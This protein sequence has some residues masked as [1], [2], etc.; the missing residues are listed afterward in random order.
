MLQ[1]NRLRVSFGSKEVLKGISLE[2]PKGQTLAVIGESGAGK[3]TL[4]LTIAGLAGRPDSSA[5]RSHKGGQAEGT[6]LFQGK[7]ILLLPEEELQQLRWNK[8]ACVFQNVASA[9][10]PVLPVIDQIAEPVWQHGLGNKVTARKRALEVLAKT[11]L[12]EEKALRY[13][14]QLSGG[15]IQRALIAMALI[16]DPEVLI[17]DEP[18]ASL[19]P[20][21]RTEILGFLQ[22]ATR[23]C[24]VL[25]ITHDLAAASLLSTRTAVLY[26]GRVVEEGPTA[27]VLRTPHHPYMRALLRSYPHMTT[28]K[29]IQSLKQSSEESTQGCPFRPRCTQAVEICQK[30]VP[31]LKEYSINLKHP[32]PGR[33]ETGRTENIAKVA[34]HRGGIVPYLVVHKLNMRYNTSFNL[35]DISFIIF[36]GETVALVGPSGSGKST[37][38]KLIMGLSQPD[39]GKLLLEEKAVPFPRPRDFYQRVQMVFQN[40]Y[41]AVN[42]GMTVRQVITE[43]LVVQKIGSEQER[44]AEAARVLFEVGLPSSPDFME[45][46]PDCLS[47]GE[48]QRLAIA[49]ALIL[50]PKLLIA[51][52]PTSALDAI[53]QA[54]ILKLLMDLQEQ[55][56]LGMLFITHDLAVARK[57]ADRIIV[58]DNGKQIEQGLSWEITTKASHPLTRSLIESAAEIITYN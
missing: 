57:I 54:R 8:I 42:P 56:G 18:T 26:Q 2:L 43:P 28:T 48:I 10:N 36:E 6:V 22:K 52:E 49:R 33:T 30:S 38:A 44:T 34:C 15:E 4:A 1:I 55:R 16:N 41:D 13:P 58:M 31:P 35:Q 29:D 27:S 51:D 23:D 11:G 9:L 40:P 7:N 24:A 39:Q 47:G 45:S 25:L 17:L 19:D 3:T 12:S 21:V 14:H 20:V 50:K 5:G 53:V 37:I 46:Y 32:S